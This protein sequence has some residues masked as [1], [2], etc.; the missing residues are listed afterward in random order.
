L[1]LRIRLPLFPETVEELAL[2]RFWL[3]ALSQVSFEYVEMDV[4]FNPQLLALLFSSDKTNPFRF[5]CSKEMINMQISAALGQHICAPSIEIN[6][7][8]GQNWD[9]L[10]HFLCSTSVV[11]RMATIIDWSNIGPNDCQFLIQVV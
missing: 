10:F 3:G 11:P 7:K 8:E 6:I 4:F 9:E 5:R 2:V 1:P